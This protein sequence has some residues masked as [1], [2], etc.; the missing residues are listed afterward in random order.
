MQAK[1]VVKFFAV[2]LI[3]VCIYQLSFTWIS[4][5]VENDAEEYAQ[6][7]TERMRFQDQDS[8]YAFAQKKEQ[9]YLDSI[10]NE[11]VY[12]L[13]IKEYTYNETKEL[14]LNLGLDLQGGMSVTL[15]IS[16]EELV[17]KMANDSKNP[18]FLRAIELAN[19]RQENSQENYITLFGNAINEIDPDFQLS[20]I[21]S[22]L[23][24]K[25][26]INFNSSNAEVLD[27]IKEEADDAVERTYNILRTRIDKFGVTQPNIA[28][29]KSNGRISVELPGVKDPERVRKLLQATAKLEFWE[30]YENNNEMLSYLNDA[31]K[32]LA[33]QNKL[34]KGDTNT[35]ISES[36]N[37]E[38]TTDPLND[39]LGDEDTKNDELVISEIGDS[40]S[41][42][43]LTDLLNVEG[44]TADIED[45]S[46][47]ETSAE[48]NPLFAVLYPAGNN[49]E[50]GFV[51]QPGAVVGYA[52][53]KDIK[54][55]NEYLNMDIVRSSFPR[56]LKLLWG[57]KPYADESDV[58]QLYAIKTRTSDTRAPL[59]GDVINDAK[60]DFA[61]DGQVEVSMSMNT[62][63]ARIWKRMTNEAAGAPDNEKDNKCIA[64]VLDNVVYS[65]PRVNG[66]ISGGRSSISGSF[67]IAEAKDLAN[68]LKAGKL[69]APARIVEEEIVGPSLGS[70]SI[71]AG[72]KSLVGGLALVL[73]FMI[74]Y[75]SGGGIVANIALIFNLFFIIGI[76]SSL[77]ATLTLP[78]I[79]GIVL[80]IGMSVDANVLIFERIK[81]ELLRGK[82][83]RLAI[84]DGYKNSYTSI[85]DANLT[86]LL[87]GIILAFFGS[88]PILG[89]ATVLIIGI[90]SSLF[91][92][93]LITRLIID[94]Y[95]SKDKV[96]SFANG[97][98][99]KAFR[100][101]N[102]AFLSKRKIAY[103][104]SS[105]LILAGL[106][107][108]ISKG[109][110]LGVDFKGG[111][112]YVVRF[113]EPVNTATVRES[114]FDEFNEYP[115]V[116]TFGASNQ[117]K[118]NTAYMIDD[119]SVE[120]DSIIERKLYDG[121]NIFLP[122]QTSFNIFLSD[123]KMSSQKVGPTI[124]D[125]IKKG[126]VWATIFALIGIFIYLLIRFKKWQFGLG[127]VLALFHDVMIVLGLF[128]LLS[129]ILPFS[130]EIDQAFIAAILTVIGYSINDTVVVFD[131]IREY[132]A[133]HPTTE[134]KKVFN[135][136]INSTL[137]RTMI[138]SVTTLLVVL[139]LF[140]FGG[141]VIRGFS[142]ALL[143]GI[144][145]GTYS[146]IFIAAPAVADL[147]KE[148]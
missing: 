33:E 7:F 106:A 48:D 105:I 16:L 27:V 19:K 102:I 8:L 21:F 39:L 95:I 73:V 67:E 24:N 72:L 135:M 128:S 77:G 63:G 92:A 18:T 83:L 26:K 144:L 109:F 35:A 111:R 115:I 69:P 131:R 43:E 134:K 34:L 22:S 40:V 17:K 80:T 147:E 108:I 136:A 133:L 12:D 61:P 84:I 103:V 56:N 119:K 62:E 116:K 5:K 148:K 76:L 99:K 81:E 52:R 122:E 110:E 97:A 89:F 94:I 146:S 75:Y 47:S 54:K 4:S 11:V 37:D 28:L 140:I 79:A 82:G 121:L 139:V 98:T 68:I 46:L 138:T 113:D 14:Q 124:A 41:E 114:L 31:N 87:T 129:G 55:V 58:Y 1:G 32:K 25:E 29:Q 6:S 145:A 57:A 123:Y 2:A 93:I 143:V 142:F 141:E 130:L 66:E 59:G 20:S 38:K 90:L 127:A 49:T 96:I 42:N 74:I 78:G 64:I 104:V 36:E 10:G 45:A 88:G 101:L 132:L 117:V 118:I 50:Q 30:T 60:Q 3:L 71:D 15:Q 65:A 53:A 70:E 100:N 112:T 44:D 126:A 107:S 23:E 13:L 51:L 91:T 120:T 9:E 85:I 86:T 125:D 137:S